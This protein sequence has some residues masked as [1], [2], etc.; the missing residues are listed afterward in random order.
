MARTQRAPRY[1][2]DQIGALP[3]PVVERA[4]EVA[5]SA[6]LNINGWAADPDARMPLPAIDIVI[7]SVPYAA[8]YG[9]ERPD[10]A[11]YLKRPDLTKSGFLFVVPASQLSPGA[12][13]IS[14][15]I[16]CPDNK[17]YF[18]APPYQ[19]MIR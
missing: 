4:V 13:T 2:V 3:N 15:R 9:M 8:T 16:V 11:S 7:D 12:H 19:V 14:L 17:S 6:T 18:E 1:Y 10:V 5:A